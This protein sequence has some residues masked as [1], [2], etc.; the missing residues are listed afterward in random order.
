MFLKRL[1]AHPATLALAD[2][3]SEAYPHLEKPRRVKDA[4]GTEYGK[5]YSTLK[6][7]LS[8]CTGQI[9]DAPLSPW[10]A[11]L[12]SGTPINFRRHE[13]EAVCGRQ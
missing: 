4:V 13:N 9:S 5:R 8:A 11:R 7:M 1:K 12:C 3:M 10:T 6:H 2:L